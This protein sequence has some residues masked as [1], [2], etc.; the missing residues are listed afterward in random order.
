MCIRDRYDRIAIYK[1][2]KDAEPRVTIKKGEFYEAYLDD[3]FKGDTKYTVNR[4][5]RVFGMNDDGSM[6]KMWVSSGLDITNDILW[7]PKSLFKEVTDNV[8]YPP[9]ATVLGGADRTL[10]CDCMIANW[11]HVGAWQANSMRHL[12]K[13]EQ[14]QVVFSHFHNIDA[15][16]HMIVK[17]MKDKGLTPNLTEADFAEFL[18]RIYVQTDEY[19]GYFMDML[20]DG[21][22]IFIVSDH[23][24][25][26]PENDPPLIGDITGVNVRV[27]QELGFT[28]LK[29]GPNGEELREI[30]WEKTRAIASR[31]NH[32][33]LNIKGRWPNGIVDP[34]DQYELEEE[35]MTALYGYKDPKTGKRV[36]ALALRNKDAVILGTGGPESGDI[37]YFTAEGYNYDHADSL[38][39]TLGFGGTS[40]SPIFI[41]AGPGLKKGFET[42][43]IIR[44]VDV[45]PTIAVIGG[46]RMPRECEGAPV[47]QIID[48]EE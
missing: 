23:A 13:K 15:Q 16:G 47:Y 33:Y 10:I 14:Y 21:W 22:T 37:I 36:I 2:K 12:I 46:V 9:P 1:S 26:C 4:N 48:C 30:D 43:R 40:V 25:V 39:T 3:A 24:Q 19:I 45:A 42:T 11:D 31:G 6:V 38:S 29:Y 34:A 7:H 8:G 35:I 32:I 5:I 27:M 41:A 28:V 17:Y 18:E 44:E 20:D